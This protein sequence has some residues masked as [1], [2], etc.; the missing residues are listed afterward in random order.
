MAR[1]AMCRQVPVMEEMSPPLYV[2]G[3]FLKS[4][5]TSGDRKKNQ[6]EDKPSSHYSPESSG[7]SKCDSSRHLEDYKVDKDGKDQ[8]K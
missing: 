7:C 4:F 3:F 8:K 6:Q 5:K 2:R 1:Q